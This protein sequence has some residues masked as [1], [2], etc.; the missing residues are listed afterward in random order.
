MA[1]V[2]L[3]RGRQ[4]RVAAGHPWV[5]GNEVENVHGHYQPGDIVD[6]V[7]HRGRFLGRGYINPASQILVRLLTRAEE[8]IDE[9]F[10]RRR[11][12][13]A[14]AYRQT[15]LEGSGALEPDGACR[16]IYSEADGLPGLVV[17]RFAD[18]LVVQ[19]LT[20]G[21]DRWQAV[22]VDELDRLLAPAVI[23]ER[24]DASIREVEGLPLRARTLKGETGGPVHIREN[25]LT[26]LADVV[27]GQ[28]TGYFLDQRENR[29]VVR[30]L[31][32]SL[33]PQRVLDAFCHVGG[34]ALHAAAGGAA[35]VL[36][37]DVSDEALVMA[38]E[39]AAL[40][41]LAETIRFQNANVFDELRRMERDRERYDLIVLDPPAFAKSHSALEGA[42]RG[43]KEI[44]LRAMKL[45]PPGGYL[46]T[47]SCSFHMSPSL[48]RE[49][50]LDAARDVHRELR[51]VEERTQAKD[52]PILLGVDET[53]YL[54]CLVLQVL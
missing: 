34:F 8:T 44:N 50:V 5:Y 27:H 6:V 13:D 4:H 54:K 9:A 47:C 46:V 3:T 22:V 41:G 14:W 52:H 26:L 33:K 32:A 18:H 16:V 20:L 24:N 29:R 25:G 39:N 53:H 49:V 7:D 19:S 15:V 11:V 40:N 23:Y 2:H 17:D 42:A 21:I 48:F 36:A 37:L 35:D 10:I 1:V 45:L 31:A 43:Y 38:R 51:V 12:R 30:D 28:K